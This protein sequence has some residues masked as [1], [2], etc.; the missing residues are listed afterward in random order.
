[1]PGCAGNDRSRSDYCV[2]DMDALPQPT[3]NPT[4]P[5]TNRPTNAPTNPPTNRPTNPPTNRPT[6]SPIPVPTALPPTIPARN[7]ETVAIDIVGNNGFPA[8]KFPLGMCEGDCDSDEEVSK[9][10]GS[11][12]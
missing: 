11:A 3:N 4:N 6:D 8:S 9:N 5:P 7:S 2:L 10:Q 12:Y 1:M